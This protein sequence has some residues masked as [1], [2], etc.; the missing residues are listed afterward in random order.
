[1]Q[2]R[3]DLATVLGL[4]GDRI[5][6]VVAPAP[7]AVPL[8][9]L[10]EPPPLPA[11][12]ATAQARR[13]SLAASAAQLQAAASGVEA[14]RAGYYP[15]L[16][17]QAAYQRSGSALSGSDGVW[18]DP[19]R[20]YTASLQLVLSWNL[21]EGRRTQAALQRAELGADRVRASTAKTSDTVA[22]ELATAR[23]RVVA[24]SGEAALSAENLDVAEQGLTL[25]RQRLEAGLGTQLEVR[26]AT[27]KLTQAELSLL[28][29]RIDHAVAVADLTRAAGGAL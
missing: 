12:L 7:L 11:L 8:T 26:D 14:A 10:A 19:T 27:L 3:S 25:A 2:A 24:L 29:A 5:V 1:V 16:A 22:Q 9:A 21:F 20:G 17:A 15:T 18:G 6:G 28:Q 13:P 4:P 23:Q